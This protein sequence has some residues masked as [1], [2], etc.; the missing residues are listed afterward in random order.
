MAGTEVEDP[1]EAAMEATPT[2]KDLTTGEAAQ[3]HD[4]VWGGDIEVFSVHLLLRNSKTCT[5]AVRY[6]VGG[7]NHPQVFAVITLPPDEVAGRAHQSPKRFAM[8]RRVQR[9]EAHAFM[10]ASHHLI[11]T[12]IRQIIMRSMGPPQ[13]H[14]G[15]VEDAIGQTLV[16][17]G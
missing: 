7:S 6:R 14:I 1:A 17:I 2:A 4:L 11:G 9:N 12:F 16:S 13:Q 8:N 3:E 5:E 10:Y 15:I